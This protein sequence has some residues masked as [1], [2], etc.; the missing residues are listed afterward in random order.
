MYLYICGS[1]GGRSGSLVPFGAK[2]WEAVT[3]STT[4]NPAKKSYVVELSASSV[5]P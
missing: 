5:N 3:L 2:L 4:R 1:M